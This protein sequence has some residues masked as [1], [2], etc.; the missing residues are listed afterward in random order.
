[1]YRMK[2]DTLH[3]IENVDPYTLDSFRS[4]SA[5]R[6]QRVKLNVAPFGDLKMYTSDKY[7]I[8]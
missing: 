1:M 5:Q 7:N 2:L 4:V 3:H 8:F 6:L